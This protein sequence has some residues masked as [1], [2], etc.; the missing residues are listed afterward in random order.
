MGFIHFAQ[1]TNVINRIISQNKHNPKTL[2]LVQFRLKAFV[3][4]QKLGDLEYWVPL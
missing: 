2:S 3:T 1:R 4:L